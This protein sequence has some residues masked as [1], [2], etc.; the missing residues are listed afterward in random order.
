VYQPV[1]RNAMAPGDPFAGDARENQ[2]G[3]ARFIQAIQEGGR[4]HFRGDSVLHTLPSEPHGQP[5]V[6]AQRHDLRGQGRGRSSRARVNHRKMMDWAYRVNKTRDSDL[7]RH[8]LP[9]GHRS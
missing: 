2:N 1:K 4:P 3:L 9:I 8:I 6:V 5:A 7:G